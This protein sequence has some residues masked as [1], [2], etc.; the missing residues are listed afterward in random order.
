M[1]LWLGN[2]IMRLFSCLSVAASHTA[3]VHCFS[4]IYYF[5]EH[6]TFD[7]FFSLNAE[8]VGDCCKAQRVCAQHRIALYKSD[9]IIIILGLNSCPHKLTFC[10]VL[11]FVFC[12]VV[13]LFET[14]NFQEAE[15]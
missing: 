3:H 12:L 4:F 2:N 15:Q 11:V 1:E 8:N 6:V 13:C 10:S 7:F 9:L 14:D 5:L